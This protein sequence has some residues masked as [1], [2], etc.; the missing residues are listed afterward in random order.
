MSDTEIVIGS[1][2]E[3]HAVLAGKDGKVP[4]TKDILQTYTG[5]VLRP[6]DPWPGDF[7]IEDIAWSLA[8]QCRY[9]GHTKLFYSVATHCILVA[10]FLPQS[11]KLEG[12]L[13]DASEAYLTDLPSPIKQQ[14]PEYRKIEAKVEAAIETQYR[15]IKS[16]LVKEAD[17]YVFQLEA[18][19]VMG[20]AI[21]AKF[22]LG[23]SYRRAYVEREIIDAAN[24][25]PASEAQRFLSVYNE[26]QDTRGQD[27]APMD[28]R[29]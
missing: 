6:L 7:C 2:C 15:L 4:P 5:K 16:P 11:L 24:R 9:N 18:A 8:H 17:D 26:L 28:V 10:F 14:M 22:A 23:P 29:V 3:P 27:T 21:G 20:G 1:R 19:L 12:L 13:H 25:T